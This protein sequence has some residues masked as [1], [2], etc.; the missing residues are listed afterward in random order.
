MSGTEGRGLRLEAIRIELTGADANLFD[1]Y[2]RVHAQNVG[3]LDWASN[4]ADAGTAGFGYRLEAIEV[5]VVPK[6]SAA[7]GETAKA[8][9]QS[10]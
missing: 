7:P 5:R 2:Y 6:G 4:G 3:W 8:Y 9:I 1:V 10:L